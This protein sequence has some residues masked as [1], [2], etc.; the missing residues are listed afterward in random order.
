V[1]A[2]I[3]TAEKDTAIRLTLEKGS[4]FI[5]WQGKVR[6]ELRKDGYRLRARFNKITNRVT[7]WAEKLDKTKEAQEMSDEELG[8]EL[9]HEEQD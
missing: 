4:N 9:E 2:L 7:A 8:V 5:N 3:E 1:K 6:M